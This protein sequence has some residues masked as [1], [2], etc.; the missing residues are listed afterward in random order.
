MIRSTAGVLDLSPM[1]KYR[2][3][4]PDVSLSKPIGHAR[5]QQDWC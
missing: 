2:I 1:N 3:S 5:C 4:G